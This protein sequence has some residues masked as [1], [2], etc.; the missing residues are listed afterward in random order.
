MAGAREEKI[1]NEGRRE[2]REKS[3]EVRGSERG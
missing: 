2:R 1:D 3:R